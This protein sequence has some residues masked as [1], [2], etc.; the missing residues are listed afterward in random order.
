MP[1]L[2]EN[3]LYHPTSLLLWTAFH[4]R[5]YILL[6]QIIWP[7]HI[8]TLA[9]FPHGP[10][11]LLQHLH[12]ELSACTHSPHRQIINL[13]ASTKISSITVC[14]FRPVTLCWSLG[15]VLQFLALYKYEYACMYICKRLLL[16]LLNRVNAILL[17]AWCPMA[18]TIPVSRVYSSD[19][20]ASVQ[21]HC[22][23]FCHMYIK[24][25]VDY[26]DEWS[27]VVIAVLE[28]G[29]VTLFA[30]A[31]PLAPVFALLNNII[32]IRIDANKFL[33]QYRRPTAVRASNI[34]LS[35][36][37]TWL[38]GATGCYHRPGLRLDF[39]KLLISSV[40]VPLPVAT[41][42]CRR[43]HQGCFSRPTKT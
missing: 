27:S 10:F 25:L 20:R 41:W 34:G 28:F 21:N 13:Q 37:L 4:P 18:V 15:F 26:T 19:L 14:F 36:R 3:F 1:H 17:S 16:L 8:A 5:P 11:P 32:E 7:D 30:A 31:F 9:T 22:N 40:F 43:R 33:C 12:L 2:L 29:F 6:T 24:C 23:L 39:A 42:Q 35:Y 38:Y